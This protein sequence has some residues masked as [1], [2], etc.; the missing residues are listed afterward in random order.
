MSFWFTFWGISLISSSDSSVEFVI[1][2]NLSLFLFFFLRALSNFLF[3]FHRFL[4]LFHEHIFLLISLLVL[5]T[6]FKVLSS[7]SL[8]SSMLSRDSFS[9]CVLVLSLPLC[10]SDSN[11]WLALGICLYLE[12][13]KF[14]DWLWVLGTEVG[15]FLWTH[16]ALDLGRRWVEAVL[17]REP[18][19]G[20][21]YLGH[22]QSS[23]FS[24]PWRI[25]LMSL[26]KMFFLCLGL[27]RLA[28][29][30]RA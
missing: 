15:V 6:V 17:C 13:W 1:S 30:H 12:M 2:K 10:R 4:S 8:M 19:R 7:V 29:R 16:F 24:S 25:L 23:L 20:E 22:H 28:I 9:F 27:K 11:V 18:R 26:E 3:L 14:K 5:I 21:F